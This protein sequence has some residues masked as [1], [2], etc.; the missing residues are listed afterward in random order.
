M[1]IAAWLSDGGDTT[2]GA[3]NDTTS[4]GTSAGACAGDG[5]GTGVTHSP[6]GVDT[7]RLRVCRLRGSIAHGIHANGSMVEA[8]D[9]TRRFH[10]L[11][12]PTTNTTNTPT[13]DTPTTTTTIPTAMSTA[14]TTHNNDTNTDMN[15]LTTNTTLPDA[16]TTK[17]LSL[18]L[19][20]PLPASLICV[21]EAEQLLDD[22]IDTLLT[23][24]PR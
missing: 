6:V 14:T 23:T 2:T 21:A 3:A 22:F 15:S 20:E 4:A 11:A 13:S 24:V 17:P 5:D 19:S 18:C 8:D 1:C 9:W 16:D 10:A 12:V 7:N